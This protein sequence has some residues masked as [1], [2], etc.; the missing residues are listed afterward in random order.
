MRRLSAVTTA[1]TTVLGVLVLLVLPGS[2]RADG[3]ITLDR[4]GQITDKVGALGQ[5]RPEVAT[6]LRNLDTSRHLQLFVAYVNGF[7]GQSAS[8]WAHATA[9]RN[10]LGQDDLLLAVATHDRQYAVSA[11]NDSGLT[12]SQIN[13]VNTLAIEPALRQNDWA[14]AAIGAADGYQAVL[15][16]KPVTAPAII[17]GQ[18]DPGGS[19]TSGSVLWLPVAAVGAAGVGAVML[20]SRRKR[21]AAGGTGPVR[22]AAQP[23]GQPPV[24]LPELDSQARQALVQ[25]DDAVRTSQEELGFAAA[26]FG[27][28]AAQPFTEALAFAQGEL[29]AAFRL[30]QQLDDAFPEDDPT[31]RRMLEEIL[32]RC[33]AANARLDTEAQA[34]DSLRALEA[35]A[36]EAVQRADAALAELAAGAGEAQRTVEA[37]LAR[38]PE[39]AVEPVHGY[40]GEADQR[41]EFARGS[42]AQA[43]QA[44]SGGDS[45]G[46]AVFVRAAE[47]ALDQAGTLLES[48][49]RRAGELEQAEAGLRSA[50]AETEADLAEARAV[51]GAARGGGS[52]EL[53]GRVAR[54]EQVLADVRQE[55]AAGNYDPIS[56]LRRLEEADG[57]LD[58]SLTGAR[59]QAVG[60]Q[61]A[62]ALL[63]QA[64]LTARSEVAAAQ[65]MIATHRGAI[66]STAR[67]RLAEAE[68]RLQ[69]AVAAGPGDAVSA[70]ALAQ[71]ADGLAREAQR[72]AQQDV[73]RYDPYGGGGGRPRGGGSSGAM[74]GGIILGGMLGGGGGRGR[75][76][77]FGGM[78]GGPGSFGGGGTRGRMGGGGRF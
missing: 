47:G 16:G 5:R 29:T 49:T 2:A 18:A 70:L 75:G 4:T 8:A 61:R 19:N 39:P 78:G 42:L 34:F 76:G 38:Y 14:G 33:A 57:L 30:R 45:S 46:A 51:S 13:Q 21:A 10:G 74:L 1:I 73:G 11:D 32:T 67:T 43:R 64:L 6:A 27:N 20:Y 3:P 60:E 68:R 53:S 26:Q 12:Q 66:G 48:V 63:D 50:I 41:L 15:S 69:Q 44:L 40:P 7:S 65:D 17:P 25:T 56:A 52:G 37:L 22:G 58:E 24:P 62:R 72:A 36:P 59:E 77:G 23:V 28:E 31:K 35:N 71:Q 9:Q 55:Q 54:V